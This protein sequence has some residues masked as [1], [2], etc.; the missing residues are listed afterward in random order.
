MDTPPPTSFHYTGDPVPSNADL[1]ASLTAK[2]YSKR[3]G[4]LL[5]HIRSWVPAASGPMDLP[6]RWRFRFLQELPAKSGE[7]V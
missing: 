5:A 3:D 1:E 4:D 6:P 7:T 2:G